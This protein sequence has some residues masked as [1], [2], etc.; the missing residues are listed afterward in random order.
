M[1]IGIV[2][3][4]HNNYKAVALAAALLRKR[5]VGLVL[6]CG[7]IEDGLTVRMFE[8]LPVHFVFGNCD[9]LR[10]ELRDAAAECGFVIHEP[11]GDLDLGGR[12][13][14][15][16][17]G[18]DRRLMRDIEASGHFDYLFHGHTHVAA[19]RSVGRTRVINPGALFRA[20]EKT[21]ALLELETGDLETI[22][23]DDL[24]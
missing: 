17:H 20:R 4:T 24:A 22:H 21:F 8:G 9:S 1:L 7:D 6:H 14:A 18:D 19:E 13:L 3:D 12:K 2:S 15:W 11:F 5:E 16:L 10:A 23:V